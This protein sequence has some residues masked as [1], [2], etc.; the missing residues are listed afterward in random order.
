MLYC[1]IAS[2]VN[3]LQDYSNGCS[4]EN[5]LTLNIAK[6]F[7][8]VRLSVTHV[9]NAELMVTKFLAEIG[10]PKDRLNSKKSVFVSGCSDSVS[11]S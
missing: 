1:N 6:T 7:I 11:S 2:T 4:R 9:K 5:V 3:A 10:C 8:A